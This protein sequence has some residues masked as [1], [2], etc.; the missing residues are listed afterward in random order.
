MVD[1]V[2]GQV[3]AAG[4]GHSRG[5]GPMSP[6]ATGLGRILGVVAVGIGLGSLGLAGFATVRIT[7]CD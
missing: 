2:V 4:T 7:F 1:G 5:R 3:A 6:A